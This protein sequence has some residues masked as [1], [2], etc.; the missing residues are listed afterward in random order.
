MV[1]HVTQTDPAHLLCLSAHLLC[2]PAWLSAA[3]LCV[4]HQVMRE[5]YLTLLAACHEHS[6]DAFLSNL[7]ESRW[8]HHVSQILKGR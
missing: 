8:L 3:C 2:L 6:D 4:T 5:S 1:R 7:H